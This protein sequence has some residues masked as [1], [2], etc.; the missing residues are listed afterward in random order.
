MS[1]GVSSAY[2]YATPGP[3]IKELK[4][5]SILIAILILFLAAI[6]RGD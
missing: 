4:M 2:R 3:K 6:F 5:E 1:P